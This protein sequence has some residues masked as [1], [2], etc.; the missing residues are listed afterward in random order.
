MVTSDWEQ[1]GFAVRHVPFDEWAD[2][3]TLLHRAA[4][5]SGD[6]DY[7]L[8]PVCPDCGNDLQLGYEEVAG[9]GSALAVLICDACR[10]TWQLTPDADT[11]DA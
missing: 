9:E 7:L 10:V 4:V 6:F 1:Q 8:R 5:S 2:I 3:D 11:P